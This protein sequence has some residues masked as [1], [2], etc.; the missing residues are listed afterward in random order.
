VRAHARWSGIWGG[1]VCTIGGQE[2]CSVRSMFSCCWGF[3]MGGCWCCALHGQCVGCC[4]VRVFDAPGCLRWRAGRR[5]WG[6]G[7]KWLPHMQGDIRT[8]GASVEHLQQS[9]V[10]QYM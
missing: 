2:K 10:F 5:C 9:C 3:A 7:A 4:G 8:T 6:F 1:G